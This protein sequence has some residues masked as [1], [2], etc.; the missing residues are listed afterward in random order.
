[1]KTTRTILIIVLVL[2]ALSYIT[3]Y[4][5][6]WGG[7]METYARGWNLSLIHISEPTRPY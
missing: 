4:S 7:L 1:M 5:Y 6:I 2:V 3:G